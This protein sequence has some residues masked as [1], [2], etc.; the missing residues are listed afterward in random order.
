MTE[1][2]KQKMVAEDSKELKANSGNMP[3]LALRGLIIFPNMIT[4]LLVGRDKSI[5][6]LEEVMVED[7][8]IL[9]SAQKDEAIEEPT[10]DDIYNIGTIAQ[11][12]QLMRLPDGTIKILVE[13]MQRVE[14][15]SLLQE[16]PYFEVGFKVL[17]EEEPEDET[18]IEALMRSV[19]NNFEEYVKDNKKLPP[20]TMMTVTNIEDPGRLVD[21]I[22]SHMSL[23]TK[24]QQQILEAISSRERLQRIYNILD[25]ELEILEVKNK[26]NDEV[27]Q[28]VEKRQKEYYLKE[29]MKA[30]KKELGEDGSNNEV[31][32]YKEQIKEANLPEEVE[33][34]AVEEAEKLQK[35]P[36]NANEAVV[37]RKYL[38]CILD[39]PWNNYSE[40]KL[41]IDQVEEK[42]NQDH[43]GLED[44][45]ERILEYLAVKKLSDKMK[46]PILCLVGPPGVGKTSLGRSV[47]E[48]IGKEFVRLSLGGLRDE[49]EIRGHRRTYVGARPGRIIN[50]MRDAGTKNPL[51]LLDEID[52]VK[53]DFRGD[54]A[55]ALLEV[56][57]PEQNN[58]FS[59][60]YLEVPFDLSDVMFITTANS[61]DTI[62]RPLLDRMEVIKISG[63]TEEEKVEIAKNHLL[64]KELK[65]H[66]L[67]DEQLV[68]SDNALQK[69][70]RN[71]TREAGV[72][73]LERKIASVCRKAAKKVVEGKERTTRVD[74]RNLKKY[75][76]IPKYK[77]G[78]IEAKDRRGVVTG[79]AWTSAGGDILNIEVSIVPG[80][81][82]L[83]LTGKLGDVMKE[84]AQTA[85]SYARTQADKFNFEDKFYKKY[86]IH[87]HVPQGAIP[88]DGPSAGITLATALISALADKPVSGKVAMTGEVTLRGKVLPV[89]GIKSKVLAAQRAGIEKVILC[90]E[91]EKNLE[92][93]P[94]NVK[95]DL[96]IVLVEDMEQ[97]LQEVSL[98][99]EQDED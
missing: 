88:K 29:Q 85:L 57:D 59:D 98:K 97:V 61:I 23:K 54:P 42:L 47:A 72:R 34:K 21:I 92:D 14:I 49:A 58:E 17:E 36:P 44:V 25:R 89:G 82:K 68:V 50:A 71:Y 35:M 52:K 27:R 10:F 95:Q 3:L 28:Q 37:V 80:E 86:D 2:K 87:V 48:A 91:N 1:E 16:E 63:Y 12:K 67:N 69:V 60:H 26:I 19:V 4:S 77:Y 8:K 81:G 56:L 18:E 99:D 79:L 83:T 73:N 74:L 39:L 55:A 94:D 75:L 66:G 9:L 65:N 6:A 31:E 13:G 76:G 70:I 78:K 32:Q 40:D 30:I 22:A 84:S 51:F 43:Y 53:G 41:V 5:A 62:P 20:E 11:I 38:D 24:Q 45:K 33:E 64:P 96:E 46:T 90:H 93:I 7:K 15:T